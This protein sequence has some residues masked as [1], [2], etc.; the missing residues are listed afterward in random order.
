MGLA[1]VVVTPVFLYGPLADI[2]VLQATLPGLVAAEARAEGVQIC[3]DDARLPLAG[4]R[5]GLGAVDGWLVSEPD[6]VELVT[7]I[8]EA[9]GLGRSDVITVSQ[10]GRPVAARVFPGRPGP[11]DWDAQDWSRR[12]APILRYAVQEILSLRGRIAAQDL[13]AGLPMII[14]RASGR[15]AAQTPAPADVR[16]ATEAA[17]VQEIACEI[18]HAGFFLGRA[19]TLR[20]PRFDGTPSDTLRREVFVATDAALV[21]P[22]DRVRDRVLLVEQFRMGPYGRGDPRPWM[23][24]PVAG[25]IDGG[26]SPEDAAHRECL[27]EAGLT[28]RALEKISQHYCTPGYS[29]EFFH[30]FLG[31]CDLPD[32]EQ[33]RGGLAT[34]HED[35]RTHVIDFAQ[36]MALVQSGEAN[37]GPLILCLL[38][39][40]RER[41]RLRASA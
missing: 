38:W 41:A 35:I 20:H 21:L 14:S 9:L 6:T 36:A 5:R 32:L 22:Y 2:T 24:E 10:D 15:V 17:T 16:S 23:L 33:G 8:A 3:C 29:T 40:E 27:E 39:L 7:F 34:E 4:L 31:I 11:M 30:L 18:T 26:E 37:N 19:Y 25:R 13:C 28:L 12:A 1:S